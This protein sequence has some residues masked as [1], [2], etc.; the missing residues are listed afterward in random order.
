MRFTFC[1]PADEHTRFG[2][3]AFERMVGAVIPVTHPDGSAQPG[4]VVSASV[5]GDGRS[6]DV[7]VELDAAPEILLG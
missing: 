2:P 1:L 3:A 4:L 7:T 6:A 5:A